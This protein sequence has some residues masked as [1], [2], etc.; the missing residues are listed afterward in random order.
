MTAKPRTI[1]AFATDATLSSGPEVGLA[2]RLDPGTG[3]RAQ[4]F[5]SDARIPARMLSWLFGT[6]GDWLGYFS[7]VQT[8][9]WR[10][11]AWDFFGTTTVNYSLEWLAEGNDGSWLMFSN[12]SATAI[13]A[14]KLPSSSPTGALAATGS[15]SL[16]AWTSTASNVSG[17]IVL[18]A[19]A[20][21]SGNMRVQRS[22]D[23]GA[24]YTAQTVFAGGYSCNGLVFEP[25][26]GL[27]CFVSSAPFGTLASLVFTSPDGITWT[28]RTDP[29]SNIPGA[30]GRL[31]CV[32]NGEIAMLM[33]NSLAVSTNGGVTW[34]AFAAAPIALNTGRSKAAYTTQ[35]GWIVVGLTQVARTPTLASPSWTTSTPF[36]SG[37]A[38][39]IASDGVSRYV[40]SYGNTTPGA[41]VQVC[42]DG[43]NFVPVRF[44]SAAGTDYLPFAVRYNGRQWAVLGAPSYP[45]AT[46]RVCV[47]LSTAL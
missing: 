39:D 20:D 12:T 43:I 8:L 15:P 45:F 9:N 13:V 22:T 24:T 4:G 30:F 34:G 25:V 38:T 35:Y 14:G 11:A 29:A 1:P 21:A 46:N 31:V 40:V 47:W 2:A 23:F 26:S 17:A 32:G 36:G 5:Y 16:T 10:M 3:L 37:K 18:A 44:N 19:G 27:F 6:I 28:Q 7:N 42:D 33:N 41:G